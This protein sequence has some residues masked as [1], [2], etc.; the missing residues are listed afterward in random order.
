MRAA[1]TEATR[2]IDQSAFKGQPEATG[3]QRTISALIGLKKSLL[4][5]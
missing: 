5:P 4:Q 1:S 2:R 3:E